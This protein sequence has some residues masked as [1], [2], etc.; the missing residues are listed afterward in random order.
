MDLFRIPDKGKDTA[1]INRT[2]R[3]RGEIYDK[4]M[5]IVEKKKVSFNYLVNEALVFA[6]DRLEGD[7]N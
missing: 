7:D 2:I 6:L 3:F 1:S 5:D 4:I